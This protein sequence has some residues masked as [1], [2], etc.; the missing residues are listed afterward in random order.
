[1]SPTVSSNRWT[2][3]QKLFF[4]ELLYEAHRS[5]ELKPGE[6]RDL[7]GLS[8]SFCD[9]L[10]ER[11]PSCKWDSKRVKSHYKQVVSDYRWHGKVQKIRGA[12][13]MKV[14]RGDTEMKGVHFGGPGQASSLQSYGHAG[15]QAPRN[16]L[17]VGKTVTPEVYQEVVS[18]CLYASDGDT[19]VPGYPLT[20]AK[21]NTADACGLDK[22]PN[23]LLLM[24]RSY[25][26]HG[27]SSVYSAVSKR[28]R[29][30]LGAQHFTAVRF[31]GTLEGLAKE[32][33]F[34]QESLKHE[35]NVFSQTRHAT[36]QII[37]IYESEDP[38]GFCDASLTSNLIGSC[39]ERM[40]GLHDVTFDLDLRGEF[41]SFNEHFRSEHKWIKP[42]N[43][44]FHRANRNSF[45]TIIRNFEPG[46][47]ETVQL[48]M[49]ISRTHYKPL[50]TGRHPLKALHTYIPLQCRR[51]LQSP[52]R[53]MDPKHLNPILKGFPQLESLILGESP[54]EPNT[55]FTIDLD[56]LNQKVEVLTKALKA[57]KRLRRFA[58]GLWSRRV[59]EFNIRQNRPTESKS[60]AELDTWYVNLLKN[61]L[62]KV[63]QL[64]ELCILDEDR[65]YRGTWSGDDITIRALSFED[66]G[67]REGFPNLLHGM[68]TKISQQTS[69]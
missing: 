27:E 18:G 9:R 14:V 47:L 64:E 51:Y 65:F 69:C 44:I 63:P 19:S 67:E 52:L 66:L 40:T 36:F 48:P 28:F 61:I 23:E 32:L 16:G 38:G 25:L 34:F 49:K 33:R 29:S 46:T 42:C 13:E 6:D 5:R 20:Q 37:G 43:V 3:A 56:N 15:L 7:R 41:S 53:C 30:L 11:F 2:P 21:G 60:N 39:I 68:T 1:M 10:K 17:A 62:A 58:F 55:C 45:E 8:D 31:L 26:T 57:T 54:R 50:K 4:M 12:G 24:I 35:G 22:M 59:P